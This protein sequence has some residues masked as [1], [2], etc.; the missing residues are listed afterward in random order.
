MALQCFCGVI[1]AALYFKM[2][3]LFLTQPYDRCSLL[4]Q[5]HKHQAF[6]IGFKSSSDSATAPT[7]CDAVSNF[8]GVHRKSN[9]IIVVFSLEYSLGVVPEFEHFMQ[10]NLRNTQVEIRPQSRLVHYKG[11]LRISSTSSLIANSGQ[12]VSTR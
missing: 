1:Y 2:G 8:Y 11:Q 12:I 7:A 5:K 3:I 4:H 9:S 10:S 6:A